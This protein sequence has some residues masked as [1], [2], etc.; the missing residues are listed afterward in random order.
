MASNSESTCFEASKI[1]NTDQGLHF[2]GN[3]NKSRFLTAFTYHS[4][5][6]NKPQKNKPPKPTNLQNKESNSISI[7]DL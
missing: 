1:I 7:V 4:T 3:L 2:K 6:I 5:I